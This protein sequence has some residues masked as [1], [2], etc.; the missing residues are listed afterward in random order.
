MLSKLLLAFGIAIGSLA[1]VAHAELVATPLPGDSRLVQFEYDAD[2]TYL[3]L[4]RPKALTDIHFGPDEK[5]LTVAAG[6][7]NGWELT[8]TANQ[9]H[10]FVKPKFDNTETSATVLTDKRSYQFVL[11]STSAGS[12]WYQR[13]TWQYGNTVVL[14]V[15]DIAVTAKESLPA[16][17]QRSVNAGPG[18]TPENMT[19]GYQVVGQAEFAP[20]MVFD[21]GKFTW[22]KMPSNIQELPALFAL[23]DGGD[24][25][26]INYVVKEGRDGNYL[27]AQSVVQSG[28][29]KLGKSEVR[30]VRANAA[31]RAF[32]L[33]N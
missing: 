32:G 2:Q 1:H 5:V 7:T 27:V 24:V 29:L 16:E 31:P 18:F 26:L 10:L 4:S 23:V 21:D 19:F 28:L 3:I 12:K 6:D 22:I 33:G 9:K 17:V 13:V 30:F 20:T 8:R 14:D 11:R 15:A 25:Q